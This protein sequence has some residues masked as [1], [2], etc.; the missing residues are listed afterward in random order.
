[1]ASTRRTLQARKCC[2][3]GLLLLEETTWTG[4]GK[5]KRGE[6][7]VNLRRREENEQRR[8]KGEAGRP[9]REEHREKHRTTS[10]PPIKRRDL[11]FR[12]PRPHPRRSRSG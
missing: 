6:T 9:R 10:E 2:K 5:R 11:A 12:P 7:R 1:M 4:A 3:A 8:V